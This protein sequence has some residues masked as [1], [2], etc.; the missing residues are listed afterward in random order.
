MQLSHNWNYISHKCTVISCNCI[1]YVTFFRK[2]NLYLLTAT[3]YLKKID[4]FSQW[5]PMNT[6]NFILR[7]SQVFLLM[8]HKC[9]VISR[10]CKF[11]SL[12]MSQC[13]FISHSCNY[14]LRLRLYISQW[15]FISCSVNSYLKNA[16]LYLTNATFIHLHFI[17]HSVTSY[18]IIVTLFPVI[19]NLY[20]TNYTISHKCY[21]ISGNCDFI[22]HNCV[23]ISHNVSLFLILLFFSLRHQKTSI[24]CTSIK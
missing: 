23:F 11:I 22:S 10:N 17:S 3:S 5:H 19:L 13:D 24:G 20:F 4:Y 7:I 14:F 1:F 9:N 21:L 18:L 6:Y 2:C 16:T 8:S 12:Y 15:D